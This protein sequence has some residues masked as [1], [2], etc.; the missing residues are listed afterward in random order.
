MKSHR[1]LTTFLF[2]LSFLFA[3]G[4]WN[5]DTQQN[6][7]VSDSDGEK[8]VTHIA[9]TDDGKYF[10]S[11]YGGADNYNMNLALLDSAGYALWDEPL[12]VSD[13]PQNTWVADYSLVVDHD[14]NAVVSF[15]D[16]R[17]GNPDLVVY[18]ISQDGEQLFGDDGILVTE[19]VS[20]EFF[21][22]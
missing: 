5:S 16:I 3:N 17:N 8:A 18:K 22:G 10:I 15:A 14:G 19:T 12:V 9:Q 4:Q 21:P 7:V 6:T 11:W 13:H 20:E 1:Y 2:T